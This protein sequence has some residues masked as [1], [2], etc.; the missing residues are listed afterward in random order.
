MKQKVFISTTTFG[1]FDPAPV[2]LLEREGFEVAVNP[3]RRKLTESEIAEYVR[4]VDFLVAGT[5]PITNRVIANASRLK[6]VSRCGTGCENV[7][8]K[9]FLNPRGARLSRKVS[10]R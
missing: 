2:E 3:H 10:G 8:L 4:D 5:E 6:V 7:S 1:E 9:D